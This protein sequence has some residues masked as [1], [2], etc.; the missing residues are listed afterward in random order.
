MEDLKKQLA[1]AQQ[2]LMDYRFQLASHQLKQV[3]KVR[4]LRKKIADIS[5]RLTPKK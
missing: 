3:R 2:E 5:R 4:E 1:E